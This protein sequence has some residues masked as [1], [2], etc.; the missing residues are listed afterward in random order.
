MAWNPIEWSYLTWQ[1]F[2]VI[3][4]CWNLIGAIPGILKPA[5][6]LE[7]YYNIKTEDFITLFLNRSF[8][9]IVLLFGIGYFLIAYDPKLFYGIIIM[10]IIGKILV[11]IN[12]IYLFVIGKGEKI[13]VFGAIG[14]SLFSIFFIL[15]LFSNIMK[16]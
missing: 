3:S 5:S 13:I 16:F 9:L 7:K 12:W 2:F 15:C 6:N 1:W 4:G 8:W 11:A 14:D 10:G